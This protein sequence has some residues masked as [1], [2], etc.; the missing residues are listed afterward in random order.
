M[1]YRNAKSEAFSNGKTQEQIM[2]ETETAKHLGKTG[3]YQSAIFNLLFLLQM[4][5]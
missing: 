3:G 2:K 4:R 5:V 1:K